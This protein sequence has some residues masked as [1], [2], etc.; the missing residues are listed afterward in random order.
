MCAQPYAA[1]VVEIG[2][3]LP[4]DVLTILRR[5]EGREGGDDVETFRIQGL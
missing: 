2:N 1:E 4:G 3:I 5:M